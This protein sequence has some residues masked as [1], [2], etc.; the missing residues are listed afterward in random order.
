MAEP[1][2]AFLISAASFTITSRKLSSRTGFIRT[3]RPIARRVSLP[4]PSVE[5]YLA[6]SHHRRRL[7]GGVTHVHRPRVKVL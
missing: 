5:C 2:V 4:A 7:R 1:D 3:E 6:C